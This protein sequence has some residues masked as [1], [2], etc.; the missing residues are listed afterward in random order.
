[1]LAG[2][3]C[4][5][6]TESRVGIELKSGTLGPLVITGSALDTLGNAGCRKSAVD[7][8]LT[9]SNATGFKDAAW[10]VNKGVQDDSDCTLSASNQGDR[11]T[12][13]FV[14]HLERA[15]AGGQAVFLDVSLDYWVS[16]ASK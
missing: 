15:K 16:L 5:S 11:M 3:I 1:M 7:A 6:G 10:T 4:A 12:G 8:T 9:D 13:H 14:A 2:P